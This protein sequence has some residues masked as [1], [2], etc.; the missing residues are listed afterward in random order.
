MDDGSSDGAGAAP[1]AGGAVWET[2][3]AEAAGC[4]VCVAGD[5]W[6]GEVHQDM[7]ARAA[8]VNASASAEG[9]TAGMLAD[10]AKA[11]CE[12]VPLGCGIAE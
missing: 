5:D 3:A 7:A 11:A 6:A 4:T 1:V 2:L 10:G 8:A 9:V 12:T